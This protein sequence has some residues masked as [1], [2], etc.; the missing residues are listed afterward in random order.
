MA[1]HDVLLFPTLDESLGWVAVEAAMAGLPVISTDVFALP[2]LVL[3]GRTGWT[4]PLRKNETSRWTGLWLAGAEFEQEVARAFASIQTHLVEYLMKFANSPELVKSMG[5]AARSHMTS[6]YG[7][8][9]ARR[10]LGGIYASALG[11]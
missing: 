1:S 11:R 8:E 5:A 2:E 4:I 9:G 3:H 6:L 10:S 7:C